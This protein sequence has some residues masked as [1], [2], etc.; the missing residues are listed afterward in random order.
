MSVGERMMKYFQGEEVDCQPY[1]NFM[2]DGT[3]MKMWGYDLAKL[4]DFETMCELTQRKKDE[5]GMVGTSASMNLRTVGEALGS[6]VHNPGEGKTC[7]IIDH[8]MKDYSQL[9]AM[10]NLDAFTYA[11]RKYG[12]GAKIGCLPKGL[13]EA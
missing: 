2:F 4:G 1:A 3:F 10:E 6:V 12:A 8:F 9:E 7:Y 5:Y 13:E 11:V